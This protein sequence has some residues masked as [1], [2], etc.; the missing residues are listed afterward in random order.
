MPKDRLAR[1]AVIG[2]LTD[3][4]KAEFWET[5]GFHNAENTAAELAVRFNSLQYTCHP[6][7]MGYLDGTWQLVS[8]IGLF[9]AY[10]GALLIDEFNPDNPDTTIPLQG[11]SAGGSTVIDTVG[12]NGAGIGDVSG[13]DRWIA[14]SF[15]PASEGYLSQLKITL[16]TNSGSP[17]GNIVWELRSNS[18]SSPSATILDSGVFTPTPNT[19]NI[20]NVVDGL[21]LNT[22]TTYWLVFRCQTVQS[23][24]RLFVFKSNNSNPYASGQKKNSDNGGSSWSGGANTEDLTLT[25]IT[26]ADKVRDKLSQAFSTLETLDLDSARLRLKKHGSPT[27]NLTVKLYSESAGEP[28]TLLATSSAVSAASLS[29]SF[30]WVSFTFPTPYTLPDGEYW[31]VLETTDTPSQSNWVE[32]QAQSD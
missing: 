24:S 12:S 21:F 17:T 7:M 23:S 18:G 14:Q 6:K 22:S 9:D 16:S 3:L 4:G 32:W 20:V 5:F 28:S 15:V 26:S 2:Q 27:G 29:S 10:Q 31:L 11:M 25:I 8:A 1:A 13:N 19:Q 30:S